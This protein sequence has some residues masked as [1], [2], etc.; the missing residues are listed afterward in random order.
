V[1]VV[2]EGEAEREAIA[3]DSCGLG[4]IFEDAFAF[5]VK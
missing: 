3:R 2:D 5:V 1:V 4:D